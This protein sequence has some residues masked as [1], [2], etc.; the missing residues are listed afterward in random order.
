MAKKYINKKL[1]K[2]AA[3]VS[4][5]LDPELPGIIN[6]FAVQSLSCIWIFVTPWTA[7]HQAS[8]SFISQS[9]LKLMSVELVMYWS[10]SQWDIPEIET[11]MWTKVL[12]LPHCVTSNHSLDPYVS[13]VSQVALVV[14][15]LAACQWR[16]HKR[17]ACSIPGSERSP[18]GGQGSPLQCPCLENPMGRGVMGHRVTT[19]SDTTE[20]DLTH[21]GLVMTLTAMKTGDRLTS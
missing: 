16:R 21:A 2:R 13:G 1:I 18:G 6:R 10:I 12:P 8:P 7:A 9:L 5:R 4:S 20:S 3:W 11:L 15:N 14:K 17:W 19:K